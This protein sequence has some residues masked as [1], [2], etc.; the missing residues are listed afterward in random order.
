M[1]AVPEQNNSEQDQKEKMKQA[2]QRKERARQERV[3]HEE[4]RLKIK[5]M[6]GPAGNKRFFRRKTG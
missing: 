4:G 2:L 5:S 6:S 3:A 1:T